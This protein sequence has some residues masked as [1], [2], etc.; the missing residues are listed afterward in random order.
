MIDK[1]NPVKPMSDFKH[2][3]RLIMFENTT[4]QTL[5]QTA[6]LIAKK[7]IETIL[8]S[9]KKNSNK[10]SIDGDLLVGGVK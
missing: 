2:R 1:P 8:K 3:T 10:D 7:E 4:A 5:K 9:N 6:K